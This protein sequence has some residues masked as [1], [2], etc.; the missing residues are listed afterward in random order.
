MCKCTVQKVFTEHKIRAAI[1]GVNVEVTQGIILQEDH[2][3][4]KSKQKR[5]LQ[6]TTSQQPWAL[7]INSGRELTSMRN[8]RSG[9]K[10]IFSSHKLNV[11]EVGL[12]LTAFCT[13]CSEILIFNNTHIL[14]ETRFLFSSLLQRKN[15]KLCIYKERDRSNLI[16]S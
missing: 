3:T 4:T 13:P 1:Y 9:A 12:K 16:S 14:K 2:R 6:Y 11:R 10:C 7:Y 15:P 8:M 5:H